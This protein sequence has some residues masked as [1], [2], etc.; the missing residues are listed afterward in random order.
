MVRTAVLPGKAPSRGKWPKKT[1]QNIQVPVKSHKT[2]QIVQILE[3]QW[4]FVID[5][6]CVHCVHCVASDFLKMKKI[7]KEPKQ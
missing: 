6:T 3:D 7:N 5:L 4:Q 2:K 1:Q